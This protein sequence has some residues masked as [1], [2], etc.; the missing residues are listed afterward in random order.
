LAQ[1]VF[2]QIGVSTALIGRRSSGL[3]ALGLLCSGWLSLHLLLGILSG[4]WSAGSRTVHGVGRWMLGGI[5]RSGGCRLARIS[6]R[7]TRPCIPHLRGL[8]DGV[9]G[10]GLRGANTQRQYRTASETELFHSH[11]PLLGFSPFH[12]T[13]PAAQSEG[14]EK[15]EWKRTGSAQC[16][17]AAGF[18]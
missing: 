12:G 16:E 15:T 5:R 10:A 7:G 11:L 6:H 13:A 3:V 18:C 9:A 8:A 4:A 17:P 1:P 2:Q 14:F